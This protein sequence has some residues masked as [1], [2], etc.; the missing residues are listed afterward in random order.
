MTDQTNKVCA[1]KKQLGVLLENAAKDYSLALRNL[2]AQIAV[3]PKDI[4]DQLR[5]RADG[6]RLQSESARLALERH[7]AEHGC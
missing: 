2:S 7:I 3:V 1:E 5:A 4:Y 6:L